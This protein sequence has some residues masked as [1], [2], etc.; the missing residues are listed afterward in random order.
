VDEWIAG[1][2]IVL[3]ANP[4]YHLGEPAVKK[5]IFKV[6]PEGSSRLAMIKDGTIDVA[7]DLN[8]TQ[9]KS[10]E[11]APGLKAIHVTS[12]ED[13]VIIMNNKMSPFDNKL[14]RQAMNYACPRE[15][16][17]QTALVGYG[18]PWK[19]C[20]PMMYP[21]STPPEDFPYAYDLDKAKE[22]LIEA[23]YPDGFDVE[24]SYDADIGAHEVTGTLCKTSLA[25]I[26]V[27]VTL[28]KTPSGVLSTQL[29][30]K[31]LPFS[32][33][34][35]QP[36]SSDPN[37]AVSLIYYG[38]AYTNWPSYCNPEVDKLIEEGKTI[39]DPVER[40]EHH[41][42]IQRMIMDDAPIVFVAEADYMIVI[43]DNVK[44]WNWNT[45][46]ESF[47]ELVSFAE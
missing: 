1:D 33:W 2:R 20:I 24:L 6:I 22:L 15:D 12:N 36:L 47:L 37:Y 3:K 10:L 42:V 8:P 41:R 14:V 13:M 29:M 46:Y 27:N 45:L 32:F 18:L 28:R 39:L 26:G 35:T 5:V 11:G 40:T 25:K 38:P 7:Y 9:I 19:A 17:V 16:I 43:R 23:G 30:A 31:E 44:G 34:S 4:N 21:A